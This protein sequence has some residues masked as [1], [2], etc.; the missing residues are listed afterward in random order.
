MIQMREI[1]ERRPKAW[2]A[3]GL[4]STRKHNPRGRLESTQKLHVLE[5]RGTLR[6]GDYTLPEY[7]RRQGGKNCFMSYLVSCSEREKLGKFF[8]QKK[9]I[10]KNNEIS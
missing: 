9:S 10:Q 5:Y 2:E 7:E 3:W 1:P 6:T 4:S 8:L